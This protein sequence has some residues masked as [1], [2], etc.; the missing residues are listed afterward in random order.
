M[1]VSKATVSICVREV[2]AFF[3]QRQQRY[4]IFPNTAEQQNEIAEEFAYKYDGIP[5]CMGAID[6]THIPILRP[7]YRERDFINRKRYHSLNVMVCFINI[8]YISFIDNVI[9]K[10]IFPIQNSLFFV[11]IVRLN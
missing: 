4:I 8:L 9:L 11:L 1:G 2:A 7:H 5:N 3:Y 6:G 10:C